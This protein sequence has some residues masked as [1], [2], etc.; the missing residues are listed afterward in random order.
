MAYTDLK[1]LGEELSQTLLALFLLTNA[2]L[3]DVDFQIVTA[4]LNFDDKTTLYNSAKN[5]L[6][7]HQYCKTA[8]AKPHPSSSDGRKLL[9]EQQTLLSNLFPE[10]EISEETIESIKSFLAKEGGK[11]KKLPY[12]CWR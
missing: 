6:R 1:K 10:Q 8:N 12:K 2:N 11:K 5:A 4:Q 7:R 9:H 3:P